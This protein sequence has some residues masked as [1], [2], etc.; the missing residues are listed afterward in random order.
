MFMHYQMGSTGVG[1]V[2]DPTAMNKLFSGE[3]ILYQPSDNSNI[4]ISMPGNDKWLK[5]SIPEESHILDERRIYGFPWLP[6]DRIRRDKS[7]SQI[8]TTTV[9]DPDP[10]PQTPSRPPASHRPPILQRPI[11]ISNLFPSSSEPS[12]PPINPLEPVME[13]L[14]SLISEGKITEGDYLK[15]TNALKAGYD[16]IRSHP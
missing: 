5:L 6:A 3:I 2:S 13:L 12:P 10:V 4:C 14:D 9:P 1:W 7:Q 15:S 16:R 8:L 11:R